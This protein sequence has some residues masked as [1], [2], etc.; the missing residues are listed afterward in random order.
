VRREAVLTAEN[1]EGA[2]FTQRVESFLRFLDVLCG[3]S[4]PRDT[5]AETP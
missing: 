1:V 3:E 4:Y 5:R 2:G